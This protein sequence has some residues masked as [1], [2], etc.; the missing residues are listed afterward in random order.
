MED[1]APPADRAHLAV[2]LTMLSHDIMALVPE[3]LADRVN[4]AQRNQ[5]TENRGHPRTAAPAQPNLSHQ[6]DVS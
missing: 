1:Q 2:A 4:Q 3:V 6:R 5:L